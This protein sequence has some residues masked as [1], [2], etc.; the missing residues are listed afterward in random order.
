MARTKTTETSTYAL[1]DD[2]VCGKSKFRNVLYVALWYS[3]RYTFA[4]WCQSTLKE[5]NQIGPFDQIKTD[6][7]RHVCRRSKITLDW[8]SK[9]LGVCQSFARNFSERM[10]MKLPEM[11]LWAKCMREQMQLHY[12]VNNLSIKQSFNFQPY[13]SVTEKRHRIES[14]KLLCVGKIQMCQYKRHGIGIYSSI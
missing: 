13:S 14:E 8:N 7:L 10:A 12:M 3:M 9:V 4:L 2:G 1:A 6:K 5:A 11:L